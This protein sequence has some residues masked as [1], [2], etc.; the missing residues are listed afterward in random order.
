ML[1][2]PFLY[3]ELHAFSD[4]LLA[5][6]RGWRRLGTF[7]NSAQRWMTRNFVGRDHLDR[8]PQAFPGGSDL[9]GFPSALIIN[10][11]RGTLRASGKQ[12]AEEPRAHGRPGGGELR[13]R[14][15]TRSP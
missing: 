11:E 1:A 7:T 2:Y 10:S 9:S 8:L 5:S 15:H 3:R 14:N 4:E 6:V 12:F 13:T